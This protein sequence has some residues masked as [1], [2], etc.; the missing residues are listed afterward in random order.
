M[1]KIA[2]AIGL[3][4]AAFS[5]AV[6]AGNKPPNHC[7]RD[8]ARPANPYGSVLVPEKA[9]VAPIV[10]KPAAGSVES[11]AEP[12]S[13]GEVSPAPGAVGQAAAA[14]H[15]DKISQAGPGSLQFKS[16]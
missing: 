14:G 13:A 16:C 1:M 10:V 4:A 11:Q 3:G 15:D 6:V 12:S 2:L 7:S 5:S 8:H 9:S